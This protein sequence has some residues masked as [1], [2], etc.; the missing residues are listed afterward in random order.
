M[1]GSRY[2]V[3]V[4]AVGVMQCQRHKNYMMSVS[5][6]DRNSI[7]IYRTFEEFKRLHKELKRKFPIESGSL[8]R[9]DRALP[10]LKDAS[11]KQR[12]SG[13]LS[14]S[15]E[16]LRLLETYS[17]ELLKM[18][19]KISQSETLTQFFKAQTRDLEPS[20]PENSVVIMPSEIG[21]EKKKGRQQQHVPS[22][23]Q[24]QASQSYRCIEA[25]ET[26][27][28]KNKTFK[29][30]KKE[31]VEVLIKDMTG[32]WLVENADKQIAWFP[33]PYLQGL[34]ARGDGPS[35][36]SCQEDGCLYFAARA[37]ESQEAD[38][39]SLNNGVLVEVVRKSEDGWWLSRYNGRTGYI[40]SMCLQPYRNPHC[41]LQ[42]IALEDGEVQAHPAHE[43]TQRWK[44]LPRASSTSHLESD[45]SS[46]SSGSE[47]GRPGWQGDL[48][49]SQ[50]RSPAPAP[51]DT[52]CPHLTQRDRNDSSFAEPRAA[53]SSCSLDSEAAT[54]TPQ[55]PTRPS[56]L[57]ILQR[58]STVTRRAVR[59][60]PQ[61][62]LPQSMQ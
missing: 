42:C 1:S 48:C 47:P 26:K 23:T 2:P 14:K 54:C 61:A 59:A 58:C 21:A 50:V 45:S 3:E 6:S 38:E 13:K 57:E 55:V 31:I 5:W 27:D 7:L 32:W 10:K 24:P 19:A 20:F 46:L 36:P 60:A 39:L 12:R 25:F 43:Q 34:D 62:A 15:L 16:R 30:A 29:V 33:A 49:R 53:P 9:S 35:A 18:D 37:Y 52:Q 28:T 17:Q 44:P 51:R 8:R 56:A 41:W 22:I 40:P 4:K 11:G